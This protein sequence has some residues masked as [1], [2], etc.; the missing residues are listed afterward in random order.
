MT[1][2]SE[3]IKVN[4]SRLYEVDIM[5]LAL[6]ILLLMDHSFAPFAEIWLPVKD[7]IEIPS[8]WFIGKITSGLF[9]QMF[10]FISGYVYGMKCRN[11]QDFNWSKELIKKFKRLIIPSIFYSIIYYIV[12]GDIQKPFCDILYMI[13]CGCGH[14]WFLP[15]LFWCFAFI[16]FLEHYKINPKIV[17]I[18]SLLISLL[19]VLPLPFRLAQSS[20]YFF[21]F[22]I[23]FL[24]KRYDYSLEK[25]SI[26]QV[27]IPICSLYLICSVSSI[28]V[29]VE[30]IDESNMFIHLF[31][32]V[33]DNMILTY[34]VFWGVFFI[35]LLSLNISKKISFK[36]RRLVSS[37]AGYCFGIYIYQQ[38]IL[39]LFYYTFYDGILSIYLL[40]WIG[41]LLA[42]LCS[43]IFTYL[44]LKVP[45]GRKMLG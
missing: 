21:F 6:I 41:F 7:Q 13:I 36:V 35:L 4:N 29:K 3:N 8:Y 43:F 39:K 26:P 40:P 27:I 25:Y 15:M 20:F 5:R 9:L 42:G 2:I 18:L 28:F 32:I 10:V 24:L 33:I 17:L 45:Y 34:Y 31:R 22:Y 14:L 12:F 44:T 38:F 37:I 30:G 19:S 23:G 16:I 11:S 1:E